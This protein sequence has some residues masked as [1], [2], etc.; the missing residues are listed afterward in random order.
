MRKFLCTCSHSRPER[1]V[2]ALTTE[3]VAQGASAETS[4]WAFCLVSAGSLDLAFCFLRSFLVTLWGP[5]PKRRALLGGGSLEGHISRGASLI[6]CPSKG[7]LEVIGCSLFTWYVIASLA[8]ITLLAALKLQLKLIVLPRPQ[9]I[10]G[11]TTPLSLAGAVTTIGC[12]HPRPLSYCPSCLALC[13]SAREEVQ[14]RRVSF[15]NR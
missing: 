2:G 4:C 11:I 15:C 14:R 8:S 7:Q 12:T 6:V 13:Y 3:A 9:P 10:K 5:A 1:R